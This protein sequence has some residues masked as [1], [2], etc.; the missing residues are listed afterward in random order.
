[1]TCAL[2]ARRTRSLSS[3]I[4][5]QGLRTVRRSKVSF[6]CKVRTSCLGGRVSGCRDWPF[7]PEFRL[8][9]I[10]LPRHAYRFGALVPL[11]GQYLYYNH[12]WSRMAT[13]MLTIRVQTE[14]AKHQTPKQL[15]PQQYVPWWDGIPQAY[16]CA[17]N[18]NPAPC[19]VLGL[20]RAVFWSRVMPPQWLD[21]G[22]DQ[23]FRVQGLPRVS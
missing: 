19:M 6:G 9:F 2:D 23:A 8:V 12:V 17:V 15:H 1:M 10:R 11:Q 4:G 20:L 18:T 13:V 7:M 14:E 3:A 16:S 5:L 22:V 21:R